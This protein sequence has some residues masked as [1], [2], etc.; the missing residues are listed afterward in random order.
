MLAFK[1]EKKVVTDLA[2]NLFLRPSI[3]FVFRMGFTS[4]YDEI[5]GR[6]LRA[7]DEI[8]QSLDTTFGIHAAASFND[9]NLITALP[10]QNK[11]D[12]NVRWSSDYTTPLPLAVQRGHKEVV[13]IPL[14]NGADSN[15]QNWCYSSALHCATNSAYTPSVRILLEVDG[16]DVNPLDHEFK[17]PLDRA[18]EKIGWTSGRLKLR[19]NSD[20]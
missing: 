1:D 13:K 14:E 4:L 7:Y 8:Q 20:N 11:G 17:P 9:T 12:V 10:E 16:I 2:A 18:E 19:W 3:Q 6:P 5:I 15:A